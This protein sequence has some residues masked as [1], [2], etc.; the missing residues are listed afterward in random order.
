MVD[1]HA[2][3]A[4]NQNKADN[5]EQNWK[6]KIAQWLLLPTELIMGLWLIEPFEMHLIE[7]SQ[8]AFS[9]GI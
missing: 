1:V 8:R 3:Q 4:C 2:A 6:L 7:G 5:L 9:N